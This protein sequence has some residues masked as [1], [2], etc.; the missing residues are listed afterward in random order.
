MRYLIFR[1]AK[2]QALNIHGAALHRVCRSGAISN[3]VEAIK[4]LVQ[5]GVDVNLDLRGLVQAS[6]LQAC[7]RDYGKRAAE[8][9]NMIRARQHLHPHPRC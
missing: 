5:N 3:G 9:E 2:I 1:T 4:L 7:L 8:K 6:L